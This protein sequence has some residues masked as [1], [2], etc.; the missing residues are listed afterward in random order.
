MTTED[1]MAKGYQPNFDIDYAVGHQGELFVKRIVDSMATGSIEVKTDEMS[2]K[3]G[4]I[5][6][7]VMCLYR[8]EWKHSGVAASD[9]ELWAHIVSDEVVIVA[10]TH[11]VRRIAAYWWGAGRFLKEC[12]RG[13]HPTKGVALPIKVFINNLTDGVPDPPQ[14]LPQPSSDAGGVA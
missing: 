3:T 14:T 12:A 8:G 2:A 6:L 13:S 4:N 9:T 7:E 11:K 1:R 10:P 5:Y